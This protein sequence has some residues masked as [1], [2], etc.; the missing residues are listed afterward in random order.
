MVNITKSVSKEKLLELLNDKLYSKIIIRPTNNGE[1][2][3]NVELYYKIAN[4]A[5]EVNLITRDLQS[6]LLEC[7]KSDK[8][9]NEEKQFFGGCYTSMKRTKSIKES[10]F[11]RLLNLEIEYNLQFNIP[12]FVRNYENKSISR[13]NNQEWC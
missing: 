4:D 10:N 13:K 2:I 8:F 9:T 5:K 12:E 3:I 11:K 7:S 1:E 6:K